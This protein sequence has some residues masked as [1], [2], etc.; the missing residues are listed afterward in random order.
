MDGLHFMR[1]QT[2]EHRSCRSRGGRIEVYCMITAY[3]VI[4]YASLALA[5]P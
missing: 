3:V 5:A 4:L 1:C 2:T